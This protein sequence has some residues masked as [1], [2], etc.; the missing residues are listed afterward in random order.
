MKHHFLK[1]DAKDLWHTNDHIF[2]SSFCM[3]KMACYFSSTNLNPEVLI[4]A[5]INSS[6]LRGKLSTN[7]WRH[8][9]HTVV[10]C[11]LHLFFSLTLPQL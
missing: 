1:E 9:T 2:L 3:G 11:I 6:M 7:I 10:E 8:L 5:G 4:V